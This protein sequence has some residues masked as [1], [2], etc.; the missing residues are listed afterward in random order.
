MERRV[1][2]DHL[3]GVN[4]GFLSEILKIPLLARST[5]CIL[6]LG[7]SGTGKETCARTIHQLSKRNEGIF[8][9]VDCTALS[10]EAAEAELFDRIRKAFG[11]ETPT[12][13][14]DMSDAGCYGTLYLEHVDRLPGQAQVRVL[15]WMR[16]MQWHA[17]A[18]A[19]PGMPWVR[20]IGATAPDPRERVHSGN[21]H[22]ELHARLSVLTLRM[23][24]L[25]HRREDIPLLARHF[26]ERFRRAMNRPPL[27]LSAAGMRKLQ[28]FDWPGN[29]EELERVIER[30]VALCQSD[31]LTEA[32][33]QLDGPEP[34]GSLGS[35]REAK[36]RCVE[37]F[38]R[39][40]IEKL[41]VAHDGNISRAA[42]S[43][44]KDRR[45]FW[46]LIR[47]HGIDVERYRLS[48]QTFGRDPR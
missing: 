20:V 3:V 38:E 26:V 15:G 18:Q 37:A 13:V 48:V 40:F 25:R 2:I 21:L 42:R 16:E 33:L 11:G 45:A 5:S 47:K 44:R 23:P 1:G 6:I 36:A 30:A 27:G 10:R 28:I 24:A 29:I 43:A 17:R 32:D 39:D 12:S 7:E 8:L 46:E 41:L 19:S 35:F 4:P 31:I 9:A 14:E 34:L 22:K